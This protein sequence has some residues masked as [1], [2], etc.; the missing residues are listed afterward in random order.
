MSSITTSTTNNKATKWLFYN[1]WI[2]TACGYGAKVDFDRWPQPILELA[3]VLRFD[4]SWVRIRGITQVI[5]VRIKIKFSI[6]RSLEPLGFTPRCSEH[7]RYLFD[8]YSR[9]KPRNS[10]WFLDVKL[11][12]RPAI[13]LRASQ[14]SNIIIPSVHTQV[15]HNG[16]TIFCMFWKPKGIGG[17][18]RFLV[19]LKSVDSVRIVQLCNACELYW[20]SGCCPI[21]IAG[22][23]MSLLG[24]AVEGRALALTDQ[25][26]GG[27]VLITKSSHAFAFC[28]TQ[29]KFGSWLSLVRI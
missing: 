3:A 23:S 24:S 4:S 5:K 28:A 7:C 20:N 18:G 14:G 27:K 10:F 16:D 26:R 12:V 25:K 9:T 11:H 15:I 2:S 13:R 29:A 22:S 6:M 17:P 19:S 21:A 8:K 1:V